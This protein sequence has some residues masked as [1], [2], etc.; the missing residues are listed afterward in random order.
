MQITNKYTNESYLVQ[1]LKAK[2]QSAYSYLYSNYSAAVNGVIYKMI[3]S[4]ELAEDVLQEVFVKV[5][6]NIDNYDDSKGK[7]FTWLIKLT[8]NHTIDTLR[9][10]A[11]KKQN[12]IVSEENIE[13]A[14]VVDHNQAISKFNTQDLKQRLNILDNNQ[15]VIIDLAYFQ[16]Y[17]QEQI[18]TE[19]TIPLGTV[20]T[21]MRNA[22]LELRKALN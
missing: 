7:L 14:T 5:W 9:S 19:L 22:I 6:N 21:R 11:Y 8:R 13:W 1:A 15:K 2:E 17:T 18:A 12:S 16:G 10:K 20:K 3:S 4:R